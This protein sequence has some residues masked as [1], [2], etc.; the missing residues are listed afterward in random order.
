MP[1]SGVGNDTISAAGGDDLPD[2]G[3]GSDT[4]LGGLGNDTLTGSSGADIF[5]FDTLPHS[6]T[7]RD[8][9]S[10]FSVLDDTIELDNAIFTSLLSPGTLAAGSFRSGDGFASAADANDYLSGGATRPCELR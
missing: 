4:L 1:G 3:A 5:R 8:T 2:G 6:A 7:N 10:D 9:I